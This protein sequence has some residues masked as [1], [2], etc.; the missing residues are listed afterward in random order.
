[1]DLFVFYEFLI[2]SLLEIYILYILTSCME[3]WVSL[4]KFDLLSLTDRK[5]ILYKSIF[6]GVGHPVYICIFGIYASTV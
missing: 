5:E 6:F 1:M 4:F 3:Y 2:Y